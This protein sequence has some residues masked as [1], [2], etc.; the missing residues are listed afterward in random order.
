MVPGG[1]ARWHR[2]E[3][4]DDGNRNGGDGCSAQCTVEPGYG[5]DGSPLAGGD[6]L[7]LLSRL[8]NGPALEGYL[9]SAALGRTGCRFGWG[10]AVLAP[11]LPAAGAEQAEA[12]VYRGIY[13]S[14]PAVVNDVS[15]ADPLAALGDAFVCPCAAAADAALPNGVAVLV[16]DANGGGG[17]PQGGEGVS[18]L[19]TASSGEVTE[20]EGAYVHDG[21]RC[22][23]LVANEAAPAVRLSLVAAAAPA[24]GLESLEIAAELGGGGGAQCSAAPCDIPLVPASATEIENITAVVGPGALAV[25]L[26]ARITFDAESARALG[27]ARLPG[28]GGRFVLAY[29]QGPA[30]WLQ[31]QPVPPAAATA[32][33]VSTPPPQPTVSAAA[34]VSTP[35]Q[36]TAAAPRMLAAK[37]L[38]HQR[39]MLRHRREL[40]PAN[41]S[42]EIND[43]RATAGVGHLAPQKHAFSATSETEGRSRSASQRLRNAAAL[44]PSDW[45]LSLAAATG[46]PAPCRFQPIPDQALFNLGLSPGVPAEFEGVWTGLTVARVASSGGPLFVPYGTGRCQPHYAIGHFSVAPSGIGGESGGNTCE[47]LCVGDPD[48]NFYSYGAVSALSGGNDTAGDCLLF[49]FCTISPTTAVV[50][51]NRTYST[52]RLQT[53]L[54]DSPCAADLAIRSRAVRLYVHSCASPGSDAPAAVRISPQSGALLGVLLP[55]PSSKC[56]I[57]GAVG[58]CNTTISSVSGQPLSQPFWTGSVQWTASTRDRAVGDVDNLLLALGAPSDAD[59]AAVWPMSIAMSPIATGPLDPKAALDPRSAL[60]AGQMIRLFRAN[61]STSSV[62]APLDAGPIDR[63]AAAVACSGALASIVGFAAAEPACAALTNALLPPHN[64]SCTGGGGNGT[65]PAESR[66]VAVAGLCSAPCEPL[67]AAVVDDAARTCAAAWNS[68]PVDPAQA[69]VGA[70]GVPVLL[71]SA[72]GAEPLLEALEDLITVMTLSACLV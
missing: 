53:D 15:A 48:C 62:P 35:P 30:S 70:D 40:R 72:A 7:P 61:G 2:L 33:H 34:H 24:L 18:V 19:V 10:D 14:G 12:A 47:T 58:S 31:E 60:S 22:T 64:I 21:V 17:G 45:A 56:D 1:D 69:P 52:F 41:D 8:A 71:M 51:E 39:R 26:P 29:A 13:R 9:V 4:C 5:P 54:V 43:N 32:A 38:P 46:E 3:E 16:A 68:V 20:P 65:G 63:I 55:D 25:G 42:A 49:A 59:S 57:L 67:L 6:A 50:V 28:A 37:V 27:P 44:A 11:A 23:W 66:S 36:I